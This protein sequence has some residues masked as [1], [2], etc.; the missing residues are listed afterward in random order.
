MV[1]YLLLTDWDHAPN[2]WGKGNFHI[3]SR[4]ESGVSGVLDLR[5]GGG[6]CARFFHFFEVFPP[7]TVKKPDS[8]SR[9]LTCCLLRFL[10]CCG[11]GSSDPFDLFSF[12]WLKTLSVS[13]VFGRDFST[14]WDWLKLTIP[15]HRVLS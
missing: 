6:F 14:A 7:Q 10:L 2:G 3:F 9:F 5:S 13:L 8:K 12:R 4:G 15:T 11:G 1:I